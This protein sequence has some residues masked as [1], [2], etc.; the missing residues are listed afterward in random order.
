MVYQPVKETARLGGG[1]HRFHWLFWGGLVML[2]M[3]AGF[4]ALSA[5][6]AWWQVQQDDWHYGRPRTAQYDAVVGHNG[7]SA[8]QP[9]HF[10][11]LNLDRK[12]IVVEFPAADPAKAYTYLGPTLVGDGQDLTPVTLSFEDRNG[13]GRPDLNIHIGDQVIVF[14]NNG[15]QFVAPQQ[16]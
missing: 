2:V 15:K 13:D 10:I 12:I 4:L 3:V 16:H 11:A 14:L 8:A 9:S 6:G 7:D 5:L 1:P